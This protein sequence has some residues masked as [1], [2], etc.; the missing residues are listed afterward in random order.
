MN[1]KKEWKAIK[2]QIDL[3]FQSGRYQFEDQK[4]VT[5]NPPPPSWVEVEHV[6]IWK[7]IARDKLGG[8]FLIPHP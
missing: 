7:K 2:P 5:V 3:G 8:E 4:N 1:V 6:W